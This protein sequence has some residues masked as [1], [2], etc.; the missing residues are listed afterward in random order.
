[1]KIILVHIYGRNI[2]LSSN[3]YSFLNKIWDVYDEFDETTKGNEH[4]KWYI[5]VCDPI[6]RTYV[7]DKEKYKNFCMQLVRN[8]GCYPGDNKYLKP[9]SS[10]CQI[11][12]YWIYNSMKK[13]NI[14]DD[15]I[16]EC[17]KD[18]IRIM[19]IIK[20]KANCNYH[21]YDELYKEPMSLILLDIFESSIVTI[22]NVLMSSDESPKIPYQNYVCEFVKTHKDVYK[23]YCPNSDPNDIKGQTTCSRLS[24][25][26]QIYEYYFFNLEGLNTKVPPLDDTDEDYFSKCTSE[27]KL[28]AIS[29][30]AD[31][32]LSE[33]SP[34]RGYN[35]EISLNP[36]PSVDINGENRGNRV[37]STVST[38]LGTVAGASS[39]LA[40]LYKVNTKFHLNA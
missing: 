10:R 9:S 27:E 26:K 2:T 5:G 35:G 30:V 25:L 40:L 39:I 4:E 16:K 21:S 32:K 13:H 24:T 29:E 38:T 33:L 1:M 36:L 11:L 3:Q 20:E 8:L 12:Y 7:K 34:S 37:S 18:Y 28:S 23:K 19:G 31:H 22:R 17:F 15:V 6:I 14:P